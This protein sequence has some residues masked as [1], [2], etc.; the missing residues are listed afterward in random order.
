MEYGG[1]STLEDFYNKGTEMLQ[2]V[3]TAYAVAQGAHQYSG[4]DSSYMLDGT[5]CCWWWLRSPGYYCYDAS[6]VRG[7]GSLGD[8]L[9]YNTLGCVR[10]AF[11]LNLEALFD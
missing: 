10:P 4:S 5:G 9:V 8:Y 6:L 3:P 11:W 2:A 1:Y 7:D